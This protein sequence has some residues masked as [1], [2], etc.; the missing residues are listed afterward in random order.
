MISPH[1]EYLLHYTSISSLALILAN[2]KFKFTRLDLVDDKSE[3]ENVDPSFM[4]KYCYV[5]SWC[6][7]ET[8]NIA[9][10]K[11]YSDDM[12]G[13][14]IKLPFM[15]FQFES[16]N[17]VMSYKDIINSPSGKNN[18]I[19]KGYLELEKENNLLCQRY[20][21]SRKEQWSNLFCEIDYGA[22]YFE[23]KCNPAP[24]LDSGQMVNVLS[25][26][27]H[28][29]HIDWSF[30]NEYR[31]FFIVEN[32]EILN[33]MMEYYY[34]EKKFFSSYKKMHQKK[35][36]YI[37]IYMIMQLKIWKLLSVQSV[38]KVIEN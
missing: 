34:D 5:S 6:A 30:Q 36:P 26:I 32:G 24:K 1:P 28:N 16:N 12:R 13:V 29:K 17:T 18:V 23:T 21:L 19:I 22:D 27:G 3:S 35:K 38:L 33:N 9:L 20:D 11:M 7:D 15:P 10:W 8:E 25:I 2:K 4:A 31:Y 14:C 37:L